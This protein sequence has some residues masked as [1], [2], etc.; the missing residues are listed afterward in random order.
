MQMIIARLKRNEK[1]FLCRF[2]RLFLGD[3]FHEK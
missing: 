2:V 1:Y 3:S